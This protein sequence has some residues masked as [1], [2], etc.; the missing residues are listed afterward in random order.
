MRKFFRTLFRL[1]WLL[2]TWPFRTVYR[3][4]KPFLNWIYH[5]FKDLFAFF[6]KDEPEDAPIPDALAKAVNSPASILVHIAEFRHNLVRAVLVLV[7]FT[8]LSFAYAEP[9]LAFLAE[10][11]GG[12]DKLISTEVTENFT[13]FMKV[14]FLVGFAVSLPYILFELLRFAAP[15]LTRRER[16]F[17]LGTIP[18]ISILFLAGAGFT[19]FV[20]LKPALDIMLTLIFTTQPRP[21]SYY[22][23]ITNLMFGMGLAFQFPLVVYVLVAIGLIKEAWLSQNW[24]YA[25]VIMAIL[26]AVITPTPDPANMAIVLGPLIVV[27]YLAVGMAKIAQRAR[28][29]RLEKSQ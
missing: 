4:L 1:I 27:Y 25:I 16:L 5:I 23:T 24:R 10:P 6:S 2:I 15:G 13:V 21:S 17:A 22:T 14:S 20:M 12:I 28:D 3:I 19:F 7:L 8:G 29:R 11:V 9:I 18:A 26:A